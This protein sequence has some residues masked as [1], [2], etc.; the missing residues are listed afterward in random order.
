MDMNNENQFNM[1]DNEKVWRIEEEN[2]ENNINEW[3]AGG[4]MMKENTIC[5]N[6]WLIEEN[7]KP[8]EMTEILKPTIIE[9]AEGQRRKLT[10]IETIAL[11]TMWLIY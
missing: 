7:S 9:E 5:E 10:V 11:M 2:S 3:L 1:K 6:N 4:E 8:N